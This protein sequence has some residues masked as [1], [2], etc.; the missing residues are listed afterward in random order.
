MEDAMAVDVMLWVILAA[1]VGFIWCGCILT[2]GSSGKR[3]N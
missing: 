1:A 3:A 2:A